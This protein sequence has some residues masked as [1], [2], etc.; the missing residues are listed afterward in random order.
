MRLALRAAARGRTSPNPHVGAVIERRGRVIAIG[1]HPKAGG[2]HAEIVALRKAGARARGATIHVTLEPC[3]HFGRTPPCTDALVEAGVAKVVI[4]ARDPSGHT[5]GSIDKLERA[6]IE[7][8]SG[9]LRDEAETMI[10]DFAKHV[11]TGIPFVTL[12]S[13][14]TLDGRTATRT[15]DSKWITGERAR[16]EAHRLR[17]ASDAVLTGIGTVIADDPL[18]TVRAVRGPSPLRAI[19]DTRLRIDPRSAIAKTAKKVPTV[20]YHARASVPASLARTGLELVRL[21]RDGRSLALDDVLAD[22]GKRGVVRLLVEAGPAL[23]GALFARGL[24]DRVAVFVA[25]VLALDPEAFPLALGER[26]DRLADAPRLSRVRVRAL[27]PDLLWTG[28]LAHARSW[29]EPANRDNR[30]RA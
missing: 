14:I 30:R 22:L 15:G 9:V 16:E 20:V 29:L 6:G 17:S 24:V 2:P 12:K 21:R 4:G 27:G 18:F 3:N 8:V 11:R 7:V 5:R 28:E 13:A 19:A 1:H 26:L 10:L 23:S 25:P